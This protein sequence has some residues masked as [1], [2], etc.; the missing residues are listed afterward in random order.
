MVGVSCAVVAALVSS[1]NLE[2]RPPSEK[3]LPHSCMVKRTGCRCWQRSSIVK[4]GIPKG[5]VTC[6]FL[7]LTRLGS[8]PVLSF[9]RMFLQ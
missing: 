8:R 6:N 2:R 1:G 9:A 3:M 5:L 7:F 4:A